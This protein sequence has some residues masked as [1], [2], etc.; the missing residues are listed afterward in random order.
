MQ[1]R[2][3][4]LPSCCAA[5]VWNLSVESP[6][7][8]T[9]HCIRCA[10]PSTRTCALIV[11]TVL[12]EDL[13]TQYSSQAYMAVAAKLQRLT[14]HS[15][16]SCFAAAHCI[17]TEPCVCVH[18]YIFSLKCLSMSNSSISFCNDLIRSSQCAL[19][20]TQTTYGWHWSRLFCIAVKQREWTFATATYCVQ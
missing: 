13:Q 14:V 17:L 8:T 10:R 2:L 15:H 9:A 3:C 16:A 18:C 4:S 19:L 7:T 12:T 11:Q 1:W 5:H 20:C 6:A